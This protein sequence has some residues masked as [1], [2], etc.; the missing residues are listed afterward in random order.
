MK[1]FFTAYTSGINKS[2]LLFLVAI[3]LVVPHLSVAQTITGT[4]IDGSANLSLPGATITVTDGSGAM[5]GGV[6]TDVEGMYRLTVSGA[7]TYSVTARFLGYQEQTTVVDVTGTGTVTVD[8][9]LSQTG[10]ELNTV[11]ASTSRR[12]EKALD[13]PSSVSVLNTEEVGNHVGTSSVEALRMTMG[14]DMAQTGVDRREMVLRGF[15]NAFS[16]ATYVLTDYRQS[17]VPSLAVNLYSIMPAM[18]VDVD[19]I[20]VVRGPGSAL[21]GPGVDQG[22]VHFITKDPFRHPGTTVSFSGGEQNYLGVQF[23]Q[24]GVLG[25]K[26]NI[27]YKITGMYGQADEWE[28]DPTN[29]E[30]ALQIAADGGLRDTDFEKI[31]IN[32][33]LEYRFG[34]NGSIIA[35]GGYASITSAI[36]SGIGTLQA[37]DFGYTY[38]Q[39]RLTIGNFFAQV[40]ANKND[41][42]DSFVYGVDFDDDGKND[43]VVDKSISYNA[44]SQYNLDTWNGRQKFIFGADVE[45]TQPDTE[46]TIL[47]RNEANGGADIQEYGGYIQSTTEISPKFSLTLAARADYNNIIDDVTFSPRAAIVFKPAAGHSLRATFNRAFNSPTTNSNSL[48]I[49]AGQI[50]GTEIFIRGRGSGAGFS[51]DR[52]DAL[53][54]AY[55]TDLMASSLNPAALGAPQGVGLPLDATYGAMYEGIAA[56]PIPILTQLLNQ[57]GF[58]VDDNTTAFLVDQLS[59]AKTS[60]EG[61]TKGGLGL[62]NLTSFEIDPVGDAI[63]IAPLKSS[64]TT[65]FEVGYKGIVANQFLFAVD[66]YYSEREDFVG[67]LLN[68]TPFVFV[69]NLSSDLTAAIAAGIE[70]NA[71]LSGALGQ[72]GTSAAAVAA[73]LVALA[74]DQLPDAATPVAIAQTS[75]NNTG[76]GN[77]PELMLSYRN[78]GKVDFFGLDASFQYTSDTGL[79]VFGNASVVS[80]DFFDAE[81]LD[82]DGTDLSLALNAPALKFRLGAKY[83]LKNGLS[84]NAA[85]RYTD[86]FPVSSGPY[87]GTVPSY[88]LLDVGVGYAFGAAAP[89]LRADLTVTNALD[90]MHREFVGAPQLGRMTI[91]K[92]T[93]TRR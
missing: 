69:P 42:G 72:L 84:F 53:T 55:G 41:A 35:N 93:Y 22:V 18:N 70:G 78:F 19:R 24:A 75:Q 21:Y 38:G 10:F 90:D 85:G 52:N 14:V 58:P 46:G 67:P 29:K 17:A 89:G 49:V 71:I 65:T 88:T 77:T 15:N 80:D 59:P 61:V 23:R 44:Q 32:G 39:L 2:A 11:V 81:E 86:E 4:V 54:A 16:G 50:P 30:D 74:G 51:F 62:L 33:S 7:G 3:L 45:L 87:Q 37:D 27:G 47:G 9:V 20:E 43:I 56:I 28:L 73:T 60:V 82:E 6:V 31:N 83:Q 26:K 92:L 79:S 91:L 64:V 36:Q 25:A 12:L 68:I 40:Y 1:Q 34:P 13:A 63:D 5:I 57:A 76:I 8:F 66:V 48:D